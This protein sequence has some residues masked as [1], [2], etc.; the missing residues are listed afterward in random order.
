M[1]WGMNRGCSRD[2]LQWRHRARPALFHSTDVVSEYCALRP[3]CCDRDGR[4]S[5][6]R[7]WRALTISPDSTSRWTNRSPRGV[8]S[9]SK[10]IDGSRQIFLAIPSREGRNP[11]CTIRSAAHSSRQHGPISRSIAAGETRD[12]KS[13]ITNCSARAAMVEDGRQFGRSRTRS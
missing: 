2:D 9:Y 12:R 13:R 10:D 8:G 11:L 1:H 6:S 3:A 5:Q 4:V 7:I